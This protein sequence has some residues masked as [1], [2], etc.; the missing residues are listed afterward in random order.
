[1]VLILGSCRTQYNIQKSH[2][3]EIMGLYSPLEQHELLYFLKNNERIN[4]DIVITRD[5]EKLYNNINYLREC[6]KA[7][8]TVCIEICTNKY[9]ICKSELA[10]KKCK[11]DI[12]YLKN[13][14]IMPEFTLNFRNFGREKG[15]DKL[16]PEHF[17]LKKFDIDKYENYILKIKDLI[18]PKKL[19]IITH[20]FNSIVKE[21]MQENGW[22]DKEGR[23]MQK[24]CLIIKELENICLKH[25]IVL[26]NPGKF[27]DN[28]QLLKDENHF[29][30]KGMVVISE[31]F[32]NQISIK[33]IQ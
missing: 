28:K 21:I 29:T 31:K 3:Q 27:V 14:N 26:F 33:L 32:I 6:Y 18:Y 22:I 19:V 9:F 25:N 20:I 11:N 15:L 13:L 8:E 1:M 17:E 24:R 4:K 16:Y 5:P 7:A 23:G 2:F 10:H 12:S 30:D